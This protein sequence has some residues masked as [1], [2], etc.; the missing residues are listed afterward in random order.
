MTD[1]RPRV[2][3]LRPGLRVARRDDRTLQVGLEPD[4][5]LL[6]SDSPATRAD[7]AALSPDSDVVGALAA[8]GLV[9]DRTAVVAALSAADPADPLAQ[10]AV[11]AAFAQH[12]PAAADRLAARR[13]A[14]VSLEP[15][16]AAMAAWAA[17]A[18]R[19]PRPRGDR[20]RRRRRPDRHRDR[21]AQ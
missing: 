18:G 17:T 5:R 19:P 11:T 15:R 7:L 6:L 13:R 9:V 20:V 10:G 14:T 16:G 21:G 8:R 4:R 1:D 12:G 2:P 3:M